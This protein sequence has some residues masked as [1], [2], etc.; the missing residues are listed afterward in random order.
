MRKRCKWLKYLAALLAVGSSHA[1]M[2]NEPAGFQGV[3]WDEPFGVASARMILL[4]DEGSV[5]YYKRTGDTLQFGR[6]DTVKI[7]YRY[8]KDQFSSG[9]IQTFGGANQKAI[10]ATLAGM[11]GDPVRPRQKFLQYFWDGEKAYIVLTCEVNS[12]CV[13]EINSKA[14]IQREQAE[15]GEVAPVQRKDDD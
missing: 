9:V 5:K 4:R 13:T 2:K 15:T 14:V 6:V 12:Y 8:Y 1:E 3:T 11:Y 10:L 7:A